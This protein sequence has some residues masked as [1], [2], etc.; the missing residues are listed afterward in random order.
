MKNSTDLLSC[1]F[2]PTF[3]AHLPHGAGG[4]FVKVSK[5]A[6]IRMEH[7]SIDRYIILSKSENA[8]LKCATLLLYCI[9]TKVLNKKY[10]LKLD[11]VSRTSK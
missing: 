6:M 9:N 3:K 7:Y 10:L 8:T 5:G 11:N 2:E 4:C 1:I